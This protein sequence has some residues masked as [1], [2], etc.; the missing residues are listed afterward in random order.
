MGICAFTLLA[1]VDLSVTSEAF[2]EPGYLDNGALTE[3]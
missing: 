2:P 3:R 1:I